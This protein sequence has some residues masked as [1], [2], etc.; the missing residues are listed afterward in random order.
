[1]EDIMTKR[2]LIADDSANTR[3]ILR[4]MLQNQGFKLLEAE[5][6]EEAIA[7]ALSSSPDL[8]ILDGMMPRKCGFEACV[9][10]KKNPRTSSIP[11]I[12]LTAIAQ[13]DTSRDWTRE[14][15]ADKFM[16]KPFQ[17]KE[18]LSAIESLTGHALVSETALRR[19]SDLDPRPQGTT[20]RQ[21]NATP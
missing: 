13:I 21:R 5:N 8:I 19:K 7:K 15:P 16:A 18:L 17:M 20:I 2:V 1:L 11:V 4:F 3:G 12:I 9:E 6:G 10:L 14:A